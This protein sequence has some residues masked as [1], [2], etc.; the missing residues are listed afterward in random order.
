MLDEVRNTNFRLDLVAWPGGYK[1]DHGDGASV[2]HF[3]GEKAQ[4]IIQCDFLVHDVGILLAAEARRQ[5]DMINATSL[6]F[7]Q[8]VAIL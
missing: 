6:I 2:G 3:A 5:F 7:F 8:F 4:T 1:K